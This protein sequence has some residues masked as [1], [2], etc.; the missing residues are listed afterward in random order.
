MITT[1]TLNPAIDIVVP[2]K[3]LIPGTVSRTKAIYTY[4]GGK[5]TNVSRALASLGTDSTATGFVGIRDSRETEHFLKHHGVKSDFVACTGSNRICLLIT[6]TGKRPVETVINSES[7]IDITKK[8]TVM[9]M[10]KLELLSK[11]ST[12]MIFSGS[13]PLSLPDTFYRTAVAKVRNNTAVLLDASSKYL[14]HALK[15]KPQIL[16]QNISELESAFNVRLKPG[17][18]VKKFIKNIAEKY[19]IPVIIVTMN[20]KGALLFDRGAFL[21]YPAVKVKN[22][23]SPVGSGDAFSAGLTYGLSNKMDAEGSCRWAVAAA[24]ANLFHLGSCFISKKDTEAFLK[25]VVVKKYQDS[26]G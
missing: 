13:V 4:P 12:H 2:V 10:K 20:E 17:R 24:A 16:K 11:K 22:F 23:A 18:P 3:D 6:S 15:A 26:L 5:G 8:E 7:D 9:L 1:V 19:D 21:F 25:M 14:F